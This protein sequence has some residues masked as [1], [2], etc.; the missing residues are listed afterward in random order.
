MQRIRPI[1]VLHA[2]CL[3]GGN[4]AQ[5]ARAERALGLDSWCVSFDP[6]PFDYSVDEQLLTAG[7]GRL[8]FEWQRFRL[9][10][11]ALREFDVVHFNFGRTLF[12]TR[13]GADS[14]SNSDH[15]RI[16]RALYRVYVGMIELRDASI[17]KRARKAVFVTFQG[18][19]A[20]Q[21]NYCRQH[22]AVTWANHVGSSYYTP[23]DDRFKRARIE[24]FD[25]VADGI[26]SLN[27]DLLHVLPKRA[28]FMP[29]AHV[30]PRD[31]TSIPGRNSIEL[32]VAHAPSHRAVKGTQWII[33][34][35]E[36]LRAAG[37]RIVLRLVEGVT[38]AEARRQFAEADLCVD[39]LFAG[40]YGGVSVE[41]MALGKPVIAY[42][43]DED[44][45]FLPDQLRRD[46]PIIS[47]SP[48]SIHEVL[49]QCLAMPRARLREIGERSR[50][51]VVR[52]HDPLE[53]A[54]N[55]KRDYEAALER[56]QLG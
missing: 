32:L 3:T 53:I 54:A 19:D 4:P 34:A 5:L 47:A 31:W 46:L 8:A 25:R 1:R 23:E 40:W 29:Y 13:T 11:R 51:Y 17:L 50:A 24:Q 44:L 12:P 45:N 22:F 37:A 2:P 9:L 15:T 6:N 52:W 56:S 41:W 7:Q 14:G 39:Q 49:R 42:L 35:V 27:P 10:Y 28:R 16:A 38:H 21:G 20:R 33:N 18:D 26:Y 48:D 43:R 30:D 55:L 36:R